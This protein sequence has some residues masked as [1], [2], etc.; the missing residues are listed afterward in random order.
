MM[1]MLTLPIGAAAQGELY[2]QY[3]SRPGLAVAEVSGFK[4]CDTVSVDVVLL[5]AESDEAWQRLLKEFDIRGTEGSSSWLGELRSPG[6]RTPWTGK[7]VLR[8]VVSHA[9]KAIG[10]YRLDTE[11]QYDALVDYQMRGLKGNKQ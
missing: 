5:Q 2:R 7:P 11:V 9:R 1:F 6:R 10:L 4:L 8:V 3:A